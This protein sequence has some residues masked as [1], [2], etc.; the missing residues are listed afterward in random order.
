MGTLSSYWGTSTLMCA[1]TVRPGG[2]IGRDGLADLN[3]S[4]DVT[5]VLFVSLSITN[6]MFEHK[7]ARK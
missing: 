1:L 7:G 2:A 6:A 3:S 5:G 4:S